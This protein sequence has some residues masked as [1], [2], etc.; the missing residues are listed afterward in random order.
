MNNQSP[1]KVFDL[2]DRTFDFAMDV[3]KLT[4]KLPPTLANRRDSSQLIDSSG[5]VGANYREANES[6]SKK[7]FV[8]RAKICRKEAKES[9]YWLR[10]LDTGDDTALDKDRM[11]LVKESHELTCIFG[12]I[13]TKV[14][15]QLDK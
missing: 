4:K 5:S 12:A 11:A 13:I 3:R 1:R 10:L 2:E 15:K 7:D 6:F 9:H 8:H 14:E